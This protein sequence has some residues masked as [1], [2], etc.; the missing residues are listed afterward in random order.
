MRQT[1][2]QLHDQNTLLKAQL[3]TGTTTDS[4]NNAT[5]TPQPVLEKVKQLEVELIEKDVELEKVRKDQ[6]DLLELLTDQ[7]VKLNVYKKRL[8]E[9]GETIDADSD[10][11]SASDNEV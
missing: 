5:S 4:A 2:S 7:D 1:N 11:N 6:D 10:E 8:K 9:L 3:T